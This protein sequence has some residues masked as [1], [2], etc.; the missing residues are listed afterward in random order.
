MPYPSIVSFLTDWQ[1]AFDRQGLKL[2]GFAGLRKWLQGELSAWIGLSLLLWTIFPSAPHI[3]AAYNCSWQPF[4][5]VLM[6]ATHSLDYKSLQVLRTLQAHISLKP[7]DVYTELYNKGDST[8]YFSISW[9]VWSSQPCCGTGRGTSAPLCRYVQG[10]LVGHGW[11]VPHTFPRFQHGGVALG[12]TQWQDEL[13]LLLPAQESV[14]TSFFNPAQ[15]R[16][17]FPV[18][19]TIALFTF[20]TPKGQTPG[21]CWSRCLRRK[22]KD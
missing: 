15:V 13:L 9:C 14:A 20:H 22:L 16:P 12:A 3:H 7:S 19:I 10:W 1:A 5:S 11:A 18:Q 4:F 21:L 2:H 8:A 17:D 6:E